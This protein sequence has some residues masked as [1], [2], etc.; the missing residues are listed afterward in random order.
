MPECMGRVGSA[1]QQKDRWSKVWL[2]AWPTDR[3]GI[4]VLHKEETTKRKLICRSFVPW[5]EDFDIHRR[6][7]GP[8]VMLD[9]TMVDVVATLPSAIDIHYTLPS[10]IATKTSTMYKINRRWQKYF[11]GYLNV[12]KTSE[13]SCTGLLCSKGW[14]ILSKKWINLSTYFNNLIHQRG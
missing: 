7:Y 5:H 14:K 13:L 4:L 2:N 12:K 9:I 11:W 3:L 8:H 1:A 6:L 10:S